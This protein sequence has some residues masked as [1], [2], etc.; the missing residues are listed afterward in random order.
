MAL[1]L[2]IEP[3]SRQAAHIAAI[4]RHRVGAELMLAAT[5]EQA[6]DK[7]GDRVPDLVLV[8][9]LLS[10][11]DDA[12]LA[13]ALR[14]IAAAAHVRT[15]TIPVLAASSPKR[16][17]NEGMLAKWRRGRA[18]SPT[19]DGC[20]P[21]IF[22]EQISD[23]LREAAAE[24]AELAPELD[25]DEEPIVEDESGSSR[26]LQELSVGETAVAV[27]EADVATVSEADVVSGF[28][29][30]TIEVE[31]AIAAAAPEAVVPPATSP[32]IVEP[33]VFEP[34]VFEP[35]WAALEA[36]RPVFP[37]F[38]PRRAAFA[39]TIEAL[40]DQPAAY[41]ADTAA[42][43]PPARPD[44]DA[45]AAEETQ[46]VAAGGAWIELELEE[47]A[48][49][50]VF[51]L[52]V[53]ETSA[54]L[55]DDP[56]LITLDQPAVAAAPTQAPM[57]FAAV[58]PIAPLEPIEPAEP[59]EPVAPHPAVDDDVTIAEIFSALRG[60]DRFVVKEAPAPA[61]TM[62]LWMPLTLGGGFRWPRLEGMVAERAEAAPPRAA[63]RPARA[64]HKPEA[65]RTEKPEW[66]A[67]IASLRQDIERLKQDNPGAT[68]APAATAKRETPAV[69]PRAADP[70]R[71][72]KARGPKPV[73]DE[74][75]FFDPEQCGFAALLAKL[76]EITDAGDESD[77]RSH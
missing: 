21:A 29:Q 51:E 46:P 73:Q 26:T 31:P 47:D 65:P 28:S 6:L 7:I 25:V 52:E 40:I 18:S 58:E 14:I 11:Q 44:A 19:P 76:S 70:A 41:A 15:L 12:A 4:A 64:A 77:A 48:A 55:L 67:L 17:A 68:H 66:A 22:A 2:A 71:K 50:P 24:R 30:T 43:E 38:E 34:P 62:E 53:S 36:D 61:R 10:P 45:I 32:Q 35:D 9:A 54:L 5:T 23:Y 72:V 39:S 74:W 75:G 57:A 37:D 60:L 16:L 3:D 56:A 8:P 13:G 33:P 20:D 42:E 59:V 69:A 27:S 1:I 49:E 63:E